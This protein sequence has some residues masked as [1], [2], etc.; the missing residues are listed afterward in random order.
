MPALPHGSLSIGVDRSPVPKTMYSHECSTRTRS[1]WW[2]TTPDM[3]SIGHLGTGDLEVRIASA[4]DLEKAG[5]LIRRA[6]E[7]A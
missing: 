6:F 7:A 3:R 2:R 1:S 4:A 5:Q